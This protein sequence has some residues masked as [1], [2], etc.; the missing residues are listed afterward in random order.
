MVTVRQSR[1]VVRRHA[2]TNAEHA[3]VGFHFPGPGGRRCEL[4]LTDISISGLSFRYRDEISPIESGTSLPAV[5]IRFGT[6]EIQGDLLVMH[7]TRQVAG[8]TVCGA[9][10]YPAKDADLLK[11]KSVIAGIEAVTRD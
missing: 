7:V 1:R 10:F 2:I 11:L 5:T 8:E 9:L 4:A 6:C 3:R